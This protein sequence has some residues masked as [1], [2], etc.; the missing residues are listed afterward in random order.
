MSGRPNAI[1]AYGKVANAEHNPLQQIVMLYDGAMKFLR[2]AASDI[3]SN[4]LRAK[5]EH[6]N[7]ALDIV[8]YLQSI[9]DFERGGEVAQTLDALYTSINLLVLRASADLDAGEMRRAADLLAPVRD[10][11]AVNAGAHAGAAEAPA[12]LA[13]VRQPLPAAVFA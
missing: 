12:S 1:A 5:A 13:D 10:A 4:D 6:S 3:E 9:L 2:L 7:R 8:H 11:W